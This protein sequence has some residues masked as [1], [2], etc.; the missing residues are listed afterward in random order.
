MK[1]KSGLYFLIIFNIFFINSLYSM[2]SSGMVNSK[3]DF[4]DKKDKFIQSLRLNIINFFDKNQNIFQIY[5]DIIKHLTKVS[6]SDGD[7]ITIS[8]SKEVNKI[9]KQ[10]LVPDKVNLSKEELNTNLKNVLNEYDLMKYYDNEEFSEINLAKIFIA[11]ANVN[12]QSDQ[13]TNILILAAEKNYES[14]LNLLLRY[15]AIDINAHDAF[16]FTALSQAYEYGYD[17]IVKTIIKSP[18]LDINN[19]LLNAAK[20]GQNVLEF[21]LGSTNFDIN[22]KDKDGN[23]AL[24]LAVRYNNT[25]SVN[26]LLNYYKKKLEDI[27]VKNNNGETALTL[28]IRYNNKDI[29][30]HIL[31]EANIEI[32]VKNNEGVSPLILAIKL[33]NQEI[34]QELISDI[35]TNVNIKDDYGNTPLILAAD[36]GDGAIV[37]MLINNPN[38]DI[39]IA[40]DNGY[41]ALYY[42]RINNHKVIV[43][44]LED[45]I[46]A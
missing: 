39:D 40:N 23:T 16:G 26:V 7:L 11:G 8:K 29:I 35:R 3:R 6:L 19:A 32:N 18:K 24:M 2:K 20:Q 33:D 10:Y 13:G 46:K 14:L 38:V 21:L 15:T 45:K 34:V 36:Q 41:T 30:K 4:E 22:T 1:V 12:I 43:K 28:A 44:W 17:N 42:A 9:I 25:N 31:K 27:N 5:E 37:K